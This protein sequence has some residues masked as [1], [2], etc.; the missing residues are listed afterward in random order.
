VC[1]PR[2]K[3]DVEAIEKV[4]RRATKLLSNIKYMTY[5]KRLQLMNLPFL[6]FHRYRGDMI[7]VYKFTHGIYI[8][9]DNLLPR[10]PKSV[11]R[12]HEYKQKKD[13]VVHS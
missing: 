8:S 4:Q 6:V 13:I 12:G 9:R 1:H 3:K 2:H 5:E 7:E 10:A 11:L